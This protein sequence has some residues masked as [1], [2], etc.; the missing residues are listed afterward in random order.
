M[1]MNIEKNHSERDVEERGEENLKV[2]A[3]VSVDLRK[4]K[5][6]AGCE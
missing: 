3:M 4:K 1:S 6:N 2:K 5:V